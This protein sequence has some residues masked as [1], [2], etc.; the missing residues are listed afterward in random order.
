MLKGLKNIYDRYLILTFPTAIF[1][2]VHAHYRHELVFFWRFSSPCA[3]YN[4]KYGML[5]YHYTLFG[6]YTH[7]Q[8]GITCTH[9]MS[10]EMH[11]A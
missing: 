3:L 2:K 10:R 8:T 6:L 4:P 7:A 11:T 5:I 9:Y 1:L